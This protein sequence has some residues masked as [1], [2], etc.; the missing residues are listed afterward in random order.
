MGVQHLGLGGW[1]VSV[2]S[3]LP[4][5]LAVC[6]GLCPSSLLFLAQLIIMAPELIGGEQLLAE[7]L[8]RP[9]GGSS[10]GAG[11]RSSSRGSGRGVGTRQSP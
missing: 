11:D 4:G 10:N 5:D 3:H 2:S 6:L 9:E 7:G 8:G 1:A